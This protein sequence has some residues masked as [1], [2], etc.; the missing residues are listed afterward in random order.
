MRH[1]LMLS[2]FSLSV[3]L[4]S[5]KK[6][7]NNNPDNNNGLRTKNIF[8]LPVND[9]SC[10]IN[11]LHLETE[12][13]GGSVLYHYNSSGLIESMNEDSLRLREFSYNTSG[14]LSAV[15]NKYDGQVDDKWLFEYNQDGTVKTFFHAYEFEQN[16]DTKDTFNV[17]YPATNSIVIAVN[18]PYADSLFRDSISVDANYNPASFTR[19]RQS[20]AGGV[21]NR[22]ISI[23]YT[24][25]SLLN[26]LPSEVSAIY[27]IE[28]LYTDM[29][30]FLKYP[31]NLDYGFTFY[32]VQII[33]FGKYLQ[34]SY[35]YIG[36]GGSGPAQ[37][38][39]TNATANAKGFPVSFEI[40]PTTDVKTKYTAEYN[41]Q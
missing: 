15:T 17:S 22:L 21:G 3:L 37:A 26:P 11:S 39:L 38:N 24:Y 18:H 20:R 33:P 4:F 35:N 1:Q 27:W 7:D 41:C 10:K 25:S 29:R 28:S 31:G 6:E 36:T 8:G 12:Y 30:Y 5:C 32:Y 14:Q 2:I 9:E 19:T 23:G 16:G 40:V 13:G 34:H